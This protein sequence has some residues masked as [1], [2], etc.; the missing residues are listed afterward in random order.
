MYKKVMQTAFIVLFFAMIGIPAAAT[1]LK[2]DQVS[3]AERRKLADRAEIYKDDGTLNEN[4]TAD[5]ESWINDNIGFRSRMVIENA[6]MQFYLFNVLSNNSDMLLGPKGELNYATA[7]MITDYQH[8]N[9]YSEDVLWDIA[10]NMQYLSDYA[11]EQGAQLYYYQC[12]DK[13]S[14][15]PEYFP[16]TVI[17]YGRESKTDGIVRALRDYSDVQVISP[18]QELLDGKEFYDTYS[19]WGDPT[20]WSQRGAYIGYR[21]LMDKI[22]AHAEAPYRILEESDYDITITDQGRTVFGG[23]HKEDELEDFKIK[24]PQAVLTNEKLTVYADEKSHSFYTNEHAGNKTRLLILGDSYFNSF[25]LDDIAE[26]FYETILIWGD[27]DSDI[28]TILDAYDPD[29][30]IIENAERCDRMG[31]LIKGA[32]VITQGDVLR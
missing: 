15:Y 8:L 32:K 26:S 11:K 28:K 3:E 31:E 16:T 14:I 7:E 17:R 23:I 1:N 4:F 12:W 22:N 30:V 6:K 18:K 27:Y 21:A 25:I 2:R 9:L 29:I 10:D 13:H 5:F 20:H 19:V 24:N